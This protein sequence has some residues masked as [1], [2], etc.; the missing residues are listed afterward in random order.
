MWEIFA[1]AKRLYPALRTHTDSDAIVC[2]A[3]WGRISMKR[4]ARAFLR[5][6]FPVFRAT[7]HEK[8][9][10]LRMRFVQPATTESWMVLVTCGWTHT[11]IS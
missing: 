2:A 1:K 11:S 7:G 10:P 3:M 5:R 9:A 4:Y 8:N 6:L